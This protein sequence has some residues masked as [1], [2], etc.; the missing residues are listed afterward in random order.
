MMDK[1]QCDLANNFYIAILVFGFVLNFVNVVRNI[2][3]NGVEIYQYGVINSVCL[4]CG[5]QVLN[6][7]SPK[8]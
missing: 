7:S 2:I 5:I 1:G 8:S 3:D 6:K 4:L